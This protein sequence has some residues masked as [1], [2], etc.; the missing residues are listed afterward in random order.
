[1]TVLEDAAEAAS[2]RPPLRVDA[3]RYL[4][5]ETRS[6]QA[7]DP[8]AP[9]TRG[10][11]GS[12]VLRRAWLP[13]DGAKA[14]LT[15]ETRDGRTVRTWLCDDAAAPVKKAPHGSGP[16]PRPSGC[17]NRPAADPAVP[18]EAGAARAWLYRT[19]Q[20]GNPPDVQAFITLGDTVAERYVPPAA[21][22]ALFRAATRVPG[23]T[24]SPAAVDFAGRRG[25]AVGQTW[26]GTRYELI[27]DAAS[28][29]FLG[30]RTVVD[31]DASFRPSGGKSP[32]AGTDPAFRAAHRQGQVLYEAAVLRTAVTGRPGELP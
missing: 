7:V 17:R 9:E 30:T 13:F 20:G 28:R 12:P 8:A 4:F 29:R 2:A 3:G 15:A 32:G 22:A 14:G 1:M 23:V 5:V 11:S 18:A 27:F 21:L 25:V 16:G 6:R 26:A 24:A 10:M 31:F 19:A